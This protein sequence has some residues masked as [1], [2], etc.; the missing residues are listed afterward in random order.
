MWEQFC[1]GKQPGSY[2]TLSFPGFPCQWWFSTSILSDITLLALKAP[3]F[4]HRGVAVTVLS[5]HGLD[6]K[7]WLSHKDPT[8]GK[9]PGERQIFSAGCGGFVRHSLGAAGE[10]L[11]QG[12][13][14]CL[15]QRVDLLP[16]CPRGYFRKCGEKSWGILQSHGMEPPLRCVLQIQIDPSGYEADPTG[17]EAWRALGCQ[18]QVLSAA[19][20]SRDV[21]QGRHS[22][23]AAA[24]NKFMG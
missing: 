11:I 8:P 3:A 9:I 2:P 21:G 5:H 24:R 1:G 15:E 17:T 6:E 12:R 4:G 20:T 16:E 22:W 23:N 19:P 13:R 7:S 10:K 18:P 14:N